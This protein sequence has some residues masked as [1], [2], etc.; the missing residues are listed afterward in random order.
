M[1]CKC[2]CGKPDGRTQGVPAMCILESPCS[3]VGLDPCGRSCS[4]TFS[5]SE[6]FI[7]KRKVRSTDCVCVCVCVWCLASFMYDGRWKVKRNYFSV[8]FK[9]ISN[10]IKYFSLNATGLFWCPSIADVLF[11]RVPVTFSNTC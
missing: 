6:D 9:F 1:L 4:A 8:H 3:L 2:V 5:G 10:A 7:M 11:C